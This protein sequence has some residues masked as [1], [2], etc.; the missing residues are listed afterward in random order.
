M[1]TKKKVRQTKSTTPRAAFQA[2]RKEM[3]ERLVE[4]HREVDGL[5]IS[6]L[7]KAHL[8]LLGP[9]GT[10]KSLLVQLLS[11]IVSGGNY[12][13]ILMTRFTLPEEV[14]GPIDVAGIKNGKHERLTAGYLP[15]SHFAFLDEIFKANS[16]ILNSLLR[17]INER[18]FKQGTQQVAADL[19]VVV[20]ASNEL[21]E[22]NELDALYDRFLLRYWTNYISDRDDVRAMLRLQDKPLTCSLTL[23]N[24]HAAQAEVEQ[25]T[26]SDEMIELLLDIKDATE[27][28]GFIVSDRRWRSL[29]SVLRA[30]AY[31][32]GRDEVAENDL[33]I[34]TEILWKDPKDRPEL[35]R[36]VTK[37]ANPALHTAQ[38]ILDAAKETYGSI[39]FGKEVPD[40][41]QARVFQVIVD[42]NAQFKASVNKL[43]KL[44]N[45]KGNEAVERIVEE[46]E[47]MSQ[48]AS[49]FAAD[50]SGLNL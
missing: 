40:H 49:R 43:R 44:T 2:L 5:L 18:Q 8:L 47:E 21:P 12:F 45:G 23:A 19:E 16:S 35:V 1:A 29:L 46:I 38:E 9:P 10:A 22:S 27:K 32:E 7:A 26:I 17:L 50:V 33:L 36:V 14:Y 41:E 3:N 39:P 24:V 4:R 30:K 11:Q 6:L 42:A 48:E 25:V 34:L 20:G 13:D 15:E 31:L 28:A 37:A